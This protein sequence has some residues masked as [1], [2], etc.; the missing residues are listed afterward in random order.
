MKEI[1]QKE[2]HLQQQLA[3]LS[4][5]QEQNRKNC[6]K[7]EERENDYRLLVKKQEAFINDVL[8]TSVGEQ[9]HYFTDMEDEL[10]YLH[11]ENLRS[12]DE[13]MDDLYEKKKALKVKEEALLSERRTLLLGEKDDSEE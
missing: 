3:L 9:Q 4:E 10:S 1:E 5:H 13:K 11:R 7:L 8:S 2:A 6:W 12:L